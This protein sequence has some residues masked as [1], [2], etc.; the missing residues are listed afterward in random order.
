MRTV[1]AWMMAALYACV[2]LGL[3]W[4][5]LY[6]RIPVSWLLE[7]AADGAHLPL[8]RGHRTTVPF[9]LAWS[10]EGWR[11]GDWPLRLAPAVLVA[12]SLLLGWRRPAL[13]S[14]AHDRRF[15]YGLGLLL[16]AGGASLFWWGRI[17]VPVMLTYGDTIALIKQIA[18]ASWV[19]P[20]EPLMMHLFNG[21]SH[22]LTA[23]RGTADG[24][25][26]GQTTA[27]LCG[28]LFLLCLWALALERGRQRLD[29]VLLFAAF[30]C[31]G[32]ATQFFGYIETTLLQ[33]AA[34]AG[35][36]ASAAWTLRAPPTSQRLV[37]LASTH[38][39]MGLLLCA[40]AAGVA[41]LPALL[42]LWGL[43]IQR[44]RRRGQVRSLLRWH[45]FAS[46]LLGIVVP[47]CLV[48]WLP[49]YRQGSF[50]NSAGGGD[51]F[52]FVPWDIETARLSSD[53]V[54]YSMVSRLHA[55]DLS[56]A[57]L[58]A[59]PW[60]IPLSVSAAVLR[61]RSAEHWQRGDDALHLLL[62]V[63]A[64]GGLSVVLLWDFDFGMWGDWNIVT[65][66]LLPLHIYG[67]TVFSDAMRQCS[68]R[69]SWQRTLLLPLLLVQCALAMGMWLQFHPPGLR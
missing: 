67:W 16:A 17:P 46:V 51:S 40:H 18:E 60:A 57:M 10:S 7:K 36:L 33:T 8:I 52:R 20:A 11:W 48:V 38:A 54:Y 56:A 23:L 21:V 2:L 63:A 41:L 53:Y 45:F 4:V 15:R 12:L 5:L 66:Y 49:F 37:A 69:R 22:I 26:A 14:A 19:F 65:C 58:T 32:T 1:P 35:F 6:P 68:H 47:W 64:A 62:L 3:L 30:A 55:V 39:A 24:V 31:T 13:A 9:H 44:E 42:T 43:L 59:A 34:L 28:V 61:W 29:A 27:L 25:L 50:G